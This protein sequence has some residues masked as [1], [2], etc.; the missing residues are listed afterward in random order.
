MF[1]TTKSLDSSCHAQARPAALLTCKDNIMPLSWHMPVSKEPFMYAVCVR[2]ENYSYDLLHQHKEFALNF[3]D[4][5]YSEVFDTMGR[6]HGK[7]VD[8]FT[9]SGLSKKEAKVIQTALIQEAY[10]IYECTIV[11]ILNY[12]DHD[13]FVAQVKCIHNTQDK[14]ISPT[15]FMGRGMYETTSNK[16]R[17]VKR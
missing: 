7:D 14:E 5:S 9:L 12:G 10:M 3:L 4:I 1:K 8:K 17:R 15:L 11:D 13:V 6:V 16:P 2:D